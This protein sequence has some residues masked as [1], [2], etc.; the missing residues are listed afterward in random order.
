VG[1]DGAPFERI[2]ALRESGDK[3]PSER[4][5]HELFASYLDEIQKVIEAVDAM[6]AGSSGGA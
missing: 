4:E 1:I 6:Q 2:F 5:A 3:S